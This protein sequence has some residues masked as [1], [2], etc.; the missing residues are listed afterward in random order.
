MEIPL[1]IRYVKRVE[2]IV[3][4][5]H[6]DE[7]LLDEKNHVGECEW[8]ICVTLLY[9]DSSWRCCSLFLNEYCIC[10]QS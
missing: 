5:T 1:C 7:V 10:L 3:C 8:I 2:V 4:M 6:F 9:Y